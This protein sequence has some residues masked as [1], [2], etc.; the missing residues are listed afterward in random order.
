MC[1]RDG[2]EDVPV[3]HLC[4]LD[5]PC[6]SV[7]STGKWKSGGCSESKCMTHAKCIGN[8]AQQTLVGKYEGSE[9]LSPT[10]LAR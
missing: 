2:E 9:V 5:K 3:S 4:C 1:R 6:D 8:D 7:S 10:L